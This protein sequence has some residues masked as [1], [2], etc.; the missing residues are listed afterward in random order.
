VVQQVLSAQVDTSE[1]L[2]HHN[3]F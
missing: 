1:K 3:L 2:Q